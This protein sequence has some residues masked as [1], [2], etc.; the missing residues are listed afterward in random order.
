LKLY[1]GHFHDLLNDV[2]KEVVM[3]DIK[4]WLGAR[5]PAARSREHRATMG[6][7]LSGVRPGL[8]RH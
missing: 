4:V 7:A 2:A 1:D 8:A 5:L 3:G 6:S